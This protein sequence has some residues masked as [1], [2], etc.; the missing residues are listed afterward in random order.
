MR[1]KV[2]TSLEKGYLICFWERGKCVKCGSGQR[3]REKIPP[4]TLARKSNFKYIQKCPLQQ[5]TGQ[6]GS[7]A[8]F[9]NLYPEIW[10]IF[11][12]NNIYAVY[13]V[14][15]CIYYICIYACIITHTHIHMK[16]LLNVR[17]I[18]GSNGLFSQSINLNF[19]G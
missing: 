13:Y 16:Y 3:E 5:E 6:G 10:E 12:L 1:P 18:N 8:L 14:H 4:E 17:D 11:S 19:W 2:Q 7:T 15:I 9:L